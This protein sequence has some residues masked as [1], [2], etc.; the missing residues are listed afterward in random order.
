LRRFRERNV[1]A[2]I[3]AD[4]HRAEHLGGHYEKAR[5]IML[6]AGYTKAVLFNGDSWIDDAL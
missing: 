1:R 3:T 4:A 6:K 2:V 5:E